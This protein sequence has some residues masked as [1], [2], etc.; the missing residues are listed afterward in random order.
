MFRRHTLSS[1]PCLDPGL[2][3]G[4]IVVCDT[5]NGADEA[6]KSGAIGSIFSGPDDVAFIPPPLPASA[7]NSSDFAAL[8]SYLNSSK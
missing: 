7:L 2:V 4:K 5:M 3:K 6:Y 8:G 1:R